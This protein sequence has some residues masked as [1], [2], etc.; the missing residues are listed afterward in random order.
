MR[1]GRR[2]SLLAASSASRSNRASATPS[3]RRSVH[4]SRALHELVNHSY[5]ELRRIAAR[6]I[7]ASGL[8]KTITPSSLVAESVVRLMK[9]RKPPTNDRHLCG[10]ATILMA[11]ALSDRAKFRR[12]QK[13]G[14]GV[15]PGLLGGDVVQ[16]MRNPRRDAESEPGDCSIKELRDSVLEHMARLST[17]QPRMMEILALH[18][19][20]DVP[21]PRVAELL[22]I[23]E[24]TAYRELTDGRQRLAKRMGVREK[25]R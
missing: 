22:G 18:A 23:S 24:R 19:I 5:P 4:D 21:V 16:D 12:A 10:L 9:Q 14:K 8:A 2:K 17:T 25:R 13:R 6:E 1:A 15:R 7:R 3:V 11:Q 20:L